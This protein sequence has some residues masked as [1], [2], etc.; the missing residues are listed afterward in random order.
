M[1]MG[2]KILNLRKARGW[3]QEEL[4]E[5]IGVTRQAVSRWESDSAKTDADK[6]IAVCDLFGVS[7]DYLLRDTCTADVDHCGTHPQP[8]NGLAKK[9]QAI[10]IQQWAACGA[11]LI[12]GLVML[13]LKLVYIM[14]D[15]NYVYVDSFGMGHS[16]YRAFLKLEGLRLVWW[17]SLAALLVGVFYLF[18]QPMLLKRKGNPDEE[19]DSE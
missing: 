17:L 12:G 5:R 11:A 6:I 14:Q 19:T 9:A 1:T 7:A 16:G 8:S 2:E 10:T 13:A 3:S 4:A 18:L 15:S